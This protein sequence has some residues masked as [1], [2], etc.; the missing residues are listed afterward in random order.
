MTVL[1]F[2]IGITIFLILGYLGLM[3]LLFPY[4]WFK[5]YLELE[6]SKAKKSRESYQK[7]MEEFK[8]QEGVDTSWITPYK[9]NKRKGITRFTEN[10]LV[11]ESMEWL[12]SWGVFLALQG[13]WA[14]SLYNGFDF[15][16]QNVGDFL[17]E[18]FFND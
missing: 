4:L 7:K 5:A 17:D 3:V 16:M 2:L 6:E 18:N 15:V 14:Y 1:G 13:F 10:E 9:E 11:V 8:N 12:F